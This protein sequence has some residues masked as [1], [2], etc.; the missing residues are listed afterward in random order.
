MGRDHAVIHADVPGIP[1]VG[2]MIAEKFFYPG[3]SFTLPERTIEVLATPAGAPWLK[4]G[5][6][7]DYVR[8]VKPRVAIPVHDAVLAMP[9][10]HVGMLRRLAPEGTEIRVVPSGKTTEI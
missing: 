8:V 7:V 4:I 6:V 2:Y 1:N 3:D 9:E 5:E 10:M